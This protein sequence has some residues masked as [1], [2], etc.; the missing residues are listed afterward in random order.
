MLQPNVYA[1]SVDSDLE[2]IKRSDDDNEDDD[3]ETEGEW[4][5]SP[6][7]ERVTGEAYLKGTLIACFHAN[8][9]SN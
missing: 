7:E 8:N 1:I 9:Y 2:T 4:L 3:D 5:D 6:V